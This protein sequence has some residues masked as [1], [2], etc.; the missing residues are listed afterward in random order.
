[1]AAASLMLAQAQRGNEL[2][3]AE[4]CVFDSGDQEYHHINNML[5]HSYIAEVNNHRLGQQSHIKPGGLNMNTTVP[6]IVNI[7]SCTDREGQIIF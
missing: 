4:V 1:M 2:L 6:W 3:T 7:G 5:P